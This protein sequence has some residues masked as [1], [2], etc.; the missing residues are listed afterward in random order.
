M[1]VVTN[2]TIRP[3]YKQT[4]VRVFP[5]DWEAR[6]LAEGVKLLSGQ[7]VLARHCNTDGDG[8]PYITGP[9]DFPNGV[10]QHTKF[11][12]NPETICCANDILLTVKGSGTGTPILA[13]ANYCISRQLMAIRTTDWKTRYVY[14]SL[15]Q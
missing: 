15:L 8:V 7:H 1:G 2:D 10:I 3:G 12:T 5:E 13:D 4:E 9:A 6:P 11:T 14:F